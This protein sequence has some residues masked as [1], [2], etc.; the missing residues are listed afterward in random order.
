M[1]GPGCD[2][3]VWPWRFSMV[4]GAQVA[5]AA[6]ISSTTDPNTVVNPVIRFSTAGTFGDPTTMSGGNL[7]N[8]NG[9]FQH[10]VQS[11]SN[12][13]F[14]EF[15]VLPDLGPDVSTT[16]DNTPFTLSMTVGAVNGDSTVTPNETPIFIDGVLNGTITGQE[17]SSVTATF[18]LDPN[19]LPTFRIGDYVATIT[20]IDP[21]DIVPSTTNQGRVSIQGRIDAV[22]ASGQQVPEPASI[23]VFL[24][25]LAGGI[26]LR[27]RAL[28]RPVA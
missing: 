6:D 21:V 11:P 15:Q 2:W 17:Q 1:A 28:A 4:G 22:L 20:K 5:S 27:R 9:L 13:S 10:T 24:A 3:R 7:V 25:A 19:N 14:G 18:D 12:V 23:A 16:Y 26:G 8:F